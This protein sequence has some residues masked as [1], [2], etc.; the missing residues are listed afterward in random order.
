MLIICPNCQSLYA[1]A[2][3]YG[4]RIGSVLGAGVGVGWGGCIFY[5]SGGAVGRILNSLSIIRS[6]S[7]LDLCIFAVIVGGVWIGF[8]LGSRIDSK[9]FNNYKCDRCGAT[10]SL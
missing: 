6:A 9:V 5:E 2:R 3:N 4:R 7:N 8:V 1:S 10:F